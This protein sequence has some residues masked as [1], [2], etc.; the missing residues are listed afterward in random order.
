MSSVC[1]F[2]VARHFMLASVWFCRLKCL[3]IW[4]PVF[5]L[6]WTSVGKLWASY[7]FLF[8]NVLGVAANVTI[9][10]VHD[11]GGMPSHPVSDCEDLASSFEWYI[12]EIYISREM[13]RDRERYIPH[14]SKESKYRK[15]DTMS[16]IFLSMVTMIVNFFIIIGNNRCGLKMSF[17]LSSCLINRIC[18]VVW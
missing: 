6:N 15:V 1:A 9:E 17:A 10:K 5:V 12:F 2:S 7:Y 4:V 14:I 16:T 13:G 18:Y 3:L 8:L 11:V